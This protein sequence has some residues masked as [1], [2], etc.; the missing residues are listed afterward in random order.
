M[1]K[2]KY[3]CIIDGV[4]YDFFVD[5]SKGENKI[6]SVNGKTVIEEE[7]TL[8]LNK[9][10][11]IIYYPIKIK[12]HTVVI[13]ID[14]KPLFHEYNIY[15]DGVSLIDGNRIDKEYEQ[16]KTILQNGTKY[17]IRHHTL[18]VLK[19]NLGAMLSAVLLTAV[20]NNYENIGIVV[21]LLLSFVIVPIFMPLFM[22][23]EWKHNEKIL[24]KYKQ[25]FKTEIEID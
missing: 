8:S 10:A 24:K 11:Y 3:N 16:A 13:S 21:R 9:Q 20:L 14:D 15:L 18:K 25:C 2:F 6:I 5:T 22:F 1:N 19:D 4:T 7:Y 12:N 17:F 23:V